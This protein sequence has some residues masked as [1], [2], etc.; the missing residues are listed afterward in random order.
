MHAPGLSQPS[1]GTHHT[2]HAAASCVACT[3]H[4]GTRCSSAL[5]NRCWRNPA[6]RVPKGQ[7][8]P[9]C[10][11]LAADTEA[12]LTL[13][14]SALKLPRS[15]ASANPVPKAR[16]RAMSQE[17]SLQAQARAAASERSRSHCTTADA[18]P[19]TQTPLSSLCLL[20]GKKAE[21][22]QEPPP[23]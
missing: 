12:R 15:H 14:R 10:L 22:P 1:G 20:T 23:Y 19:T 5:A 16:F 3:S 8:R 18:L 9:E 2:P 7:G 21:T 17:Q 4:R 6:H 11:A 13:A